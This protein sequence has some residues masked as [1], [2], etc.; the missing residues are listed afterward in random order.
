[1][2]TRGLLKIVVFFGAGKPY[3]PKT[4]PKITLNPLNN[5]QNRF[6]SLISRKSLKKSQNPP[7]IPKSSDPTPPTGGVSMSLVKVLNPKIFRL[8]RAKYP[9]IS[10]AAG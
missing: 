5:T 8:R 9:K 10:P 2:N 1:M 6:K 3:F 4:I 7:Y